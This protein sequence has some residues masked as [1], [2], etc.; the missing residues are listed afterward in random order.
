MQKE[1]ILA[2]IRRTAQENNG[3]PLGVIRFGQIS[4]IRPYDWGK[5]WARFGDA[6][7]EAGFEPNTL[8]GS[9]PDKYVFEKAALLAR[10]LGK[11]PTDKEMRVKRNQDGTFPNPGVYERFGSRFSLAAKVLAYCKSHEELTDIVA[12]IEQYLSANK[13]KVQ[14][15]EIVS[16]QDRVYGFVYLVKGHPGE[17]KIG[18]TNL[19]DRRLSELGATASIQQSL[20]HEIK[21]DDPA[22]IEA[23]WHKRFQDRRMRGEWF[24]L[25]AEDVKA[26]KRW[27][28]IY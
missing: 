20:I 16:D 13:A 5:H 26:F 7:R 24:K 4:G 6:Q 8:V 27:R 2:E 1:D 9:F 19:V 17:Y 22:G 14:Q 11:F 25:G 23:Y 18:R 12:L 15:G 3:K 21:T 28:K 10:E